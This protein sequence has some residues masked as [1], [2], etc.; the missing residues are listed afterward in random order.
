[1]CDNVVSAGGRYLFC[2]D[3]V[4]MAQRLFFYTAEVFFL[5]VDA[6]VVVVGAGASLRPPS[7]L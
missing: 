3:I 2:C 1:M 5:H 4:F 7:L 6:V